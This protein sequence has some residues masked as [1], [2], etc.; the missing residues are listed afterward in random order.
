MQIFSVGC[1]SMDVRAW[2]LRLLAINF[3]LGIRFWDVNFAWVC[4]ILAIVDKK[5]VKFDKGVN[6]SDLLMEGF[7][8]YILKFMK[9]FLVIR[10]WGNFLPW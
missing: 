5:C 6:K 7:Q 1:L 10:F 9:S 2:P 3:C 4:R 8:F